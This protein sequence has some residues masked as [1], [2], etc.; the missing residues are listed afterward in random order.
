MT[1]E[2]TDEPIAGQVIAQSIAPSTKATAG[3]TIILTIAK[4]SQT[5]EISSMAD[6]NGETATVP[7]VLGY[8]VEFALNLLHDTGL[9]TMVYYEHSDTPKNGVFSMT[10]DD[11]EVA[12]KTAPIGSRIVLHVSDVPNYA[13]GMPNFVG[14]EEAEAEKL[15]ESLGL[16]AK[17]EDSESLEP[18]GTVIAQSLEAGTIVQQGMLIILQIASE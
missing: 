12:G 9:E 1:F 14:M 4:N 17:A 8:H 16:M 13:S 3:D 18:V 6:E 15:C 5:S 10:L 7:D 11:E 2:E